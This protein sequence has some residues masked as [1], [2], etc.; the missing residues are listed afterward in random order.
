MMTRMKQL[1]RPLYRALI[2]APILKQII[3][4]EMANSFQRETADSFEKYLIRDFV[5]GRYG[6][7]Y[8]LAKPDRSRLV[9][10]FVRNTAA[11][12]S[13]TGSLVHL[14]L[15]REILSIPPQVKG[16]VIECGVWKG[17]SSASL[18]LVCEK[19]GRRLLVC[20]SFAGL[21]DDGMERHLAPHFGIYGHYQPGMFC[22]AL[23]EV[24]ANIAKFGNISICEFVPG[25]FS[26]SL[27]KLSDPIAFAFLD[28]DLV[29]STK[30]C[31]LS[32]W[33]RLI[34]GG[35][36]YTDDAGD[37][38]VVRVF[39]DQTWWQENLRCPAPGYIGS[40]CGLPL[41]PNFSSLGYTRKIS[42]F[43]PSQWKRAAHLYYPDEG[44]IPG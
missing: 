21:P 33:P 32:I 34:E 42:K 1:A 30:D 17:A 43:D 12:E 4:R 14:I 18:S 7:A 44:K 6:E 40:G 22:G 29:S 24:K 10:S 13:G 28:V 38:E 31:L 5:D 19:V 20:D 16:D 8:G 41:T 27:K 23:P 36:T 11:I 2:H 26:E 35:L 39:F 37:L 15:A 3:Q 9:E 25:Y